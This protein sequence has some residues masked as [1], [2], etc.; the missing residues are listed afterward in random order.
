MASPPP[1]PPPSPHVLSTAYVVS[2][3]QINTSAI[4]ASLSGAA[5]LIGYAWLRGWMGVYQKR[6]V[7]VF[8][9]CHETP[10]MP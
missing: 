4:L 8:P 5:V 7:S 6:M 2:D 10:H 3:S 9:T 1:A